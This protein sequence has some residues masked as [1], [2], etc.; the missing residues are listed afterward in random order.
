M[1]A[2]STIDLPLWTA[3]LECFKLVAGHATASLD[4]N[5]ALTASAHYQRVLATADLVFDPQLGQFWRLCELL[6]I[7]AHPLRHPPLPFPQLVAELCGWMQSFSPFDEFEVERLLREHDAMELMD[8][9]RYWRLLL[10]SVVRG[11]FNTAI[12]LLTRI[13]DESETRAAL[14]DIATLLIQLMHTRPTYGSGY[15]AAWPEWREQCRRE[16]MKHVDRVSFY[17]T[18][19]VL[20]MDLLVGIAEWA[21]PVDPV[22]PVDSVDPVDPVDPVDLSS[23]MAV[24][25]RDAQLD[26]TES[27]L[28]LLLFSVPRHHYGRDVVWRAARSALSITPHEVSPFTL[29]LSGDIHSALRHFSQSH[30]WFVA[31]LS[32]LLHVDG[33]DVSQSQVLQLIKQLPKTTDMSFAELAIIFDH[34]RLIECEESFGLQESL[35]AAV[36]HFDSLPRLGDV[37]LER[38][39]RLVSR[40][41]LL[42]RQLFARLTR[43]DGHLPTRLHYALETESAWLMEEML[44][45]I[46]YASLETEDPVA[47]LHAAAECLQGHRAVGKVRILR[48]YLQLMTHPT[49]AHFETLATTAIINPAFL[50]E[51]LLPAVLMMG[52][53]FV[54]SLTRETRLMMNVWVQRLGLLLQ[55]PDAARTFLPGKS[56]HAARD[57][58]PRIRRLL[59]S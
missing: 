4:T 34:L 3:L 25:V 22:D 16:L 13:N 41:S 32:D 17:P 26:W 14:G 45:Q 55:T 58:L 40:G 21:N 10:Q 48:D 23:T 7:T 18:T 20:I 49:Q 29:L 24:F 12:A 8:D 19:I 50:P 37:Q 27:L 31:H 57:I 1:A 42:H 52:T 43:M 54:S 33:T 39:M 59:L 5:V 56:I 11:R 46:M 47:L 35:F 28:V 36:T 2:M 9:A 30:P 6:H 44:N 38:A 51:F 15:Y 53:P